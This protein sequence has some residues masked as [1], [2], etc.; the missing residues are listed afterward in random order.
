MGALSKRDILYFQ[1]LYLADDVIHQADTSS[2]IRNSVPGGHHHLHHQ[3][4]VPQSVP[5]VPQY[6][7]TRGGGGTGNNA[8]E[9]NLA[10]HGHQHAHGQHYGISAG[11]GVHQSVPNVRRLL[12]AQMGTSMDSVEESSEFDMGTQHQVPQSVP[13]VPQY[14]SAELED[15]FH[16]LTLKSKIIMKFYFFIEF[17]KNIVLFKSTFQVTI[18]GVKRIFCFT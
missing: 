3:H 10:A 14:C 17:G 13:N 15:E 6:C 2:G 9:D 7:S 16:E 8:M 5:N 1:I 4:Q 11:Q 12:C 18:F